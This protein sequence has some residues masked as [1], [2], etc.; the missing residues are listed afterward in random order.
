MIS[1]LTKA[2]LYLKIFGLTKIPLLWFCRPKIIYL[3]EKS[4]EIKIPLKRRTKNHLGSMYF[5]ALSVGADIT[6][7]FL[8]MI[9]IQNSKRKVAL[10]FKDFKADFLK[11]AEGDVH[12]RCN[13]GS[14]IIK[15]V[16]K[17]IDSGQ[18]ENMIVNIDAYV[19]SISDDIVANFELTLSLKEK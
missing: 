17:T 9:C 1:S 11:R 16:E 10:I 18:R 3:D 6:G 8:A 4:V 12:F 13:Q 7:G 2:D 5:G 19:P 14:D 15:L